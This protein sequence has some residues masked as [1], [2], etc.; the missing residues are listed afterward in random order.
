MIQR[1][2]T[3]DEAVA[4]V[5]FLAGSE[6]LVVTPLGGGITNHNYRIDYDA[7]S[8][9]LRITG[10]N[11]EQLG[12]QRDVE[13]QAN[14]AAG[15]LG[16]APEV[17]YCIEPEGYLVTRFIRG[18]NVTPQEIGRADNLRRFAA[19]IRRFHEN[20]PELRIEFSVFRRIEMFAEI[21]RQHNCRFPDSYPWLMEHFTRIEH[22]LR[23]HPFSPRPCHN[24]LLNL[25]FLADNCELYILDWEYAAMGDPMYDLANFCHHHQL[26]DE[27]FNILME[28][29][30]GQVS[31][32][33]SARVR[34]YWPMSQMYE[35]MWGVAQTGISTLDEDFQGYADTFFSRT[36]ATLQDPRFEQWLNQAADQVPT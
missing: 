5:P 15:R 1:T 34:L 21:A 31:P 6:K 16:I 29:Y 18:K 22:A 33:E 2:L 28:A 10:A 14:L 24:D 13:Y 35:A 11:T 7:G 30:S 4:R 9:V 3:V 26:A 32:R 23:M 20:G 36:M 8:C 12:I 19:R 25:N 27:Q 17:L